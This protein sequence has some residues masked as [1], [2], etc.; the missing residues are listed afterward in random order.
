M[1]CWNCGAENADDA[2]F[3]TG[4]G[5]K[6]QGDGTSQSQ[7]ANPASD[8][9][10]SQQTV[11]ATDTSQSQQTGSATDTSRSQQTGS[12][13]DTSSGASVSFNSELLEDL[14]AAFRNR[15][16]LRLT[17]FIGGALCLLPLCTFALSIVS[18]IFDFLGF[19]P[20]L[21]VLFSILGTLFHIIKISITYI[22]KIFSSPI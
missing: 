14:K 16:V 15:D 19:I 6:L 21:G 20:L 1:F 10:Q 7:Q 22:N 17:E 4:C 8:N 2:K 3:C 5:V 11:I 9:P 12:A 13:T 18:G